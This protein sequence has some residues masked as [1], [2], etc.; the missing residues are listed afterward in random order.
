MAGHGIRVLHD[1][2]SGVRGSRLW[3][4]PTG[5][6]LRDAVHRLTLATDSRLTSLRQSYGGPP[7]SWRT[8]KAEATQLMSQTVSNFRRPDRLASGTPS[9]VCSG[10]IANPRTTNPRTAN[11]RTA[12]PRHRSHL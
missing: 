9:E 6:R 12:N 8:R 1:R 10:D 4:P 3:F 11:P 2:G 7:E 5:G